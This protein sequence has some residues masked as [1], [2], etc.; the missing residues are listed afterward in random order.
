[1]RPRS[2]C[3][4]LLFAAA[5]AVAQVDK[6]ADNTKVFGAPPPSKVDKNLI[7]Y[8]TGV[9]TDANGNPVGGALVFVKDLRTKKERSIVATPQGTY[10]FEDLNKTFEYELRAAK[11]K[12]V[13]PIK[14]LT[15]FDT[16]MKPVMNLTLEEPAP[17]TVPE[18]K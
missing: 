11:G 17:P 4:A 12:L 9:V 10:K 14:K 6:P 3:I 16:R 2:I 1:M 15:S 18:K 7:R 13:S 8:V 5:I